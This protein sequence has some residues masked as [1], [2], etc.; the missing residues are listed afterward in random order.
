MYYI[1]DQD[2]ILVK[3][4]AEL[5]ETKLKQL[6][7]EIMARFGK[8]VHRSYDGAFGPY[9]LQKGIE[10]LPYVKNYVET[11]V[12]GEDENSAVS[13]GVHHSLETMHYEYD[14]FVVPELAGYVKRLLDG[15]AKVIDEIKKGPASGKKEDADEEKRAL[16]ELQDFLG[17]SQGELDAEKFQRLTE[18]VLHFH[19]LEMAEDLQEELLEYYKKVLACI[20]FKP[21]MTL[22][23][24]KWNELRR[25]Y[26]DVKAFYEG[27][28]EF[29]EEFGKIM[30]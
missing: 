24:D 13:D 6:Y 4:E 2:P 12:A 17:N 14:E 27:T 15:D 16:K 19:Q 23:K 8:Y 9:A 25:V 5:D 26:K 22:Y 20:R 1:E 21:V 10:G 3:K 28:S 7:Q 11:P 30:K 18:K 29:E